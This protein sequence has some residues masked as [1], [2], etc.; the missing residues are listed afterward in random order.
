MTP[1][2][3]GDQ[4]EGDDDEKNSLLVN[5]PSEEERGVTTQSDCAN[6]GLPGWLEEELDK[7]HDL[8]EQCSEKTD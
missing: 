4:T 2:S 7:R 8:K 6:K 1:V 5:M 3:K